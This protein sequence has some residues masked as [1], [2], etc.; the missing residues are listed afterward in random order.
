MH[1]KISEKG[2]EVLN[3]KELAAKLVMTVVNKKSELEKGE[4]VRFDKTLGVRFVTTMPE[5]QAC[6]PK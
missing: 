3:N 4:V 5:N 6:K 1:V 2:R